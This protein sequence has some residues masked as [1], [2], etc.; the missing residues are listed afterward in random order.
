MKIDKAVPL[1][2]G[3]YS[4]THVFLGVAESLRE[5]KEREARR[6][7]LINS[8]LVPGLV[9]APDPLRTRSCSEPNYRRSG[10]VDLET[11]PIP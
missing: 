6:C 5:R 4:D 3:H 1:T 2:L 10:E 8:G 9:I 7:F 11:A